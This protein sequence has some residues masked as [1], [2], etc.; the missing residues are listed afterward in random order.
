METQNVTPDK[1]GQYTV[2]LEATRSEDLPASVFIT[3]ERW[4]AVRISEFRLQRS[5]ELRLRRA[6]SV[7]LPG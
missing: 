5:Q 4:L 2:Q 1:S 6:L 3:G 7:E